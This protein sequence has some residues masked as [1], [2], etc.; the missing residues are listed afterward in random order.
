MF[1]RAERFIDGDMQMKRKFIYSEL[2]KSKNA[3]RTISL[4]LALFMILT[5][6]QPGWVI[7]YPGDAV[8]S[9]GGNPVYADADGA[10]QGNASAQGNDAVGQGND[11]L[12]Q[13]NGGST[14]D[15]A[16]KTASN[17][18]S[19][20]AVSDNETDRSVPGSGTDK[21]APDNEANKDASNNS[22]DKTSSPG[23]DPAGTAK[24]ASADAYVARVSYDGTNWTYFELLI[25]GTDP[26]TNAVVPGAFSY[27]N[28]LAGDVVVEL[29]KDS[30]T[31]YTLSQSFT[32]SGSGISSL[33]LCSTS[34]S[35]T[36]A[37][38]KNQTAGAMIITSGIDSFT[39][40]NITF[41]GANKVSANVHGGAVNTN[42]L[43]FTLTDCTFLNCQAGRMGGGV[44]HDN[45]SGTA[46]VSGCTFDACRANGPDE[47]NGGG[48]GGLF[49]NAFELTV[50]DCEFTG[51][52]T[53]RRQGAAMYHKRGASDADHSSATIENCVFTDCVAYHGCAAE[54]DAW[55]VTVTD[56]VFERCGGTGSGN[57]GALNI[58]ADGA[59]NSADA[60]T[61]SISGCTFT[62]CSTYANG[63][64]VRSTAVTNEFADCTFT[65]CVSNVKAQNPSNYNGG[66]AVACTNSRAGAV[67]TN[68][69]IA[70]CEARYGSADN[71][72]SKGGAVY[73][74][75]PVTFNSG[76]ITG[77]TSK[78][79]GGIYA[80][81][82]TMNGGTVT[83]CV[84]TTSAAVHAARNAASSVL[85]SGTVIVRGNTD[86]SGN[87]RNV[88]LDKQSDKLILSQGL[89]AGADVGVYVTDSLYEANGR[90]GKTF[91]TTTS[92]ASDNL[93]AFFSD[94]PEA[95]YA[96]MRGKSGANASK[97]YWIEYVARV[98]NDDGATWTYFEAL[99]TGV[100]DG[101]L[102]EGAVDYIFGPPVL[103][104][105]VILETM[106]ET[107]RRYTLPTHANFPDAL[108][109][110]SLTVRTSELV[111]NAEG[112]QLKSRIVRGYAGNASLFNILLRCPVTVENLIVDG[113]GRAGSNGSA[114]NLPAGNSSIVS[115][116]KN[117]DF[118]NCVTSGTGNFSGGA[119]YAGRVL[120]VEDSTFTGCGASVSGGAIYTDQPLII[121]GCTFRE[122]VTQIN[123]G[124]VY[125]NVF[126]SVTVTDSEFI[127]CKAALGSSGGMGG[128]AIYST[129]SVT[130]TGTSFTE[131]TAGN[132]S[133]NQN[134]RGG[135]I[136]AQST[137]TVTD[138]GF[139]SCS[140]TD[141]GSNSN[142]GALY[143]NA[144]AVVTDSSFSGCT[145]H[146]NGG[147]V[148]CVQN[149][150][151]TGC[152]FT[153]C[154]AGANGGA[155]YSA[156]TSAPPNLIVRESVFT[157]CSAVSNGGAIYS[158]NSTGLFNDTFTGCRSNANG[159]AV[160]AASANSS[161]TLT[162]QG[163]SFA[164]CVA[165]VSGGAVYS[166]TP[167]NA[168]DDTFTDCESSADGGA[169]RLNA[170]TLLGCGFSG[171][172]AG[173]NGG[174]ICIEKSLT[175][176][177]ST[178]SDCAAQKGS[179]L[180]Y[181]ASNAQSGD[182]L[183]LTDSSIEAC[184]ASAEN[185]G[186]LNFSTAAY[187]TAVFDG[188]VTVRANTNSQHDTGCEHNVVL[189]S[190]S[191]TV[192]TTSQGGLGA[193]ADIGIYVAGVMSGAETNPYRDHGGAGDPFGT[194]AA[195]GSTDNFDKF[196]NDRN[197][198]NGMPGDASQRT[199]I[200][201]VF[202]KVIGGQTFVDFDDE[203][204]AVSNDSSYTVRF[205]VSSTDP[206][207]TFSRTA[208]GE[209]SGT[210]GS[211]VLP[212][213]TTIILRVNDSR[214]YYYV[215]AG[216]ESGGIPLSAFAKMGGHSAEL[217]D[218]VTDGSYFA[219]VI[220]DFSGAALS[221][222]IGPSVLGTAIVY[223]AG[224]ADDRNSGK[225]TLVENA[226]FE[227]TE[228]TGNTDL[229][230][231][232]RAVTNAF[233]TVNSGRADIWDNRDI[234]LVLEPA[235]SD[236]ALPAD[237]RLGVTIGGSPYELAPNADGRFIIP[238]GAPG[239]SF[240][241]DITVTLTSGFFPRIETEYVFTAYLFVANSKA[242]LA[243][244]NGL[245]NGSR[246]AAASAT[247]VFVNA[248]ND[249]PS[250]KISTSKTLYDISET[251]AVTIETLNVSD[252]CSVTA[253][254]YVKGATWDAAVRKQAVT[255]KAAGEE[256][257]SPWTFTFVPDEGLTAD[258]SYRVVV[259][260]KD[261]E[262]T[263]AE[264]VY[265]FLGIVDADAGN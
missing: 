8:Y 98:S 97:V 72:T 99:V 211:I 102:L 258:A 151:A 135:A 120:R 69:D 255:L 119:I 3:A 179:A 230:E 148:Y 23:S 68:C 173:A 74:N 5:L 166:N 106:A 252:N 79:G 260:V 51:C 15:P 150:R 50:E 249:A 210:T 49:S 168:S 194:Y 243:C 214:Y 143:G 178:V 154:L 29:L 237:V 82:I 232:V 142:G 265:H 253:A 31:A 95:G 96:V 112:E 138:S 32:F 131:C 21:T 40:E 107:H 216:S 162:L 222:L 220:V 250:V 11:A 46:V 225:V 111:K 83:G 27:A 139:T 192:I 133:S 149:M 169:M 67:F 157:G 127:S 137:L 113:S 170:G 132:N 257:E 110:T 136:Y 187:C 238:L 58:W 204:A 231:T 92:S 65:N 191:N 114:I 71:N 244:L 224:T 57:G 164:E 103:A 171:C 63:G 248:A 18:G 9:E 123:G 152:E 233:T 203:T 190:D 193:N 20:K 163:S 261:G 45:L 108:P 264:A 39:I 219:Q 61:L 94:R 200:W 159:G 36:S 93:A 121:D 167:V 183:I 117:V 59:D 47:A 101:E 26:G 247:L 48:G 10:S 124:A 125:V 186:A 86:G 254:V 188:N 212:A 184:T 1:S 62:D 6:A 218:A 25:D 241:E 128:G 236:A 146:T 201:P 234:A 226:D 165:G 122:C 160:Y 206:R 134:T 242:D 84:S 37:L 235:E 115:V 182:T 109:I 19:D 81:V 181:G 145:A 56:C 197:G 100:Y 33:I 105:D 30:D 156:V 73:V 239:G 199:I 153:E 189:E 64:A 43:T 175:L 228:N 54:S 144:S 130:A 38:V 129:G 66:G 2:I 158:N 205:K 141:T 42:A 196:I 185:G 44:Y 262:D 227:L 13:G 17:N 28:T 155:I 55:H 245:M 198:F 14:E 104:G 195:N 140:V 217:P 24:G 75:G 4:V 259:T 176:S 221:D 60:T 35:G 213:G 223:G 180:Y 87:R 118:I 209:G 256:T 41:N 34:A 263:A 208:V 174:A 52:T 89:S 85:L 90:P 16:D 161:Q 126:S 53:N 177:G 240:D 7:S 147:A 202:V 70:D 215:A 77:C 246:A 12:S 251:V 76:T 22:E 88:F 116:I 78:Q 91:A 229:S 172:S 207:L 80:S